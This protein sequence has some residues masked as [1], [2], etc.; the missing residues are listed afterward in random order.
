VHWERGFISLAASDCLW[1]LLCPAHGEAGLPLQ[2]FGRAVGVPVIRTYRLEGAL[3][4]APNGETRFSRSVLP[5]QS[6]FA[7]LYANCPVAQ[8]C[9]EVELGTLELVCLN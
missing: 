6:W 8:H 9:P 4:V 7:A 1:V 2:F 3:V 5:G